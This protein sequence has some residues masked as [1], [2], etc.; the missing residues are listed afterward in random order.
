MPWPAAA[1]LLGHGEVVTSAIRFTSA[2]AMKVPS[3]GE[4]DQAADVAAPRELGHGDL[5]LGQV[6]VENVDLLA[7]NIEGQSRQAIRAD[8]EV[9]GVAHER[10]PSSGTSLPFVQAAVRQ[11]RAGC[12]GRPGGRH[13]GRGGR[14][15]VI[16]HE[17]L[18]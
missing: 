4:Q 14:V 9:K 2:P 17:F 15:S 18:P 6:S 10:S 11:S 5:E 16:E 1:A 12:Q 7:W 8:L 13:R 3:R